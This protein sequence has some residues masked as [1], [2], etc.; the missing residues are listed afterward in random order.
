MLVPALVAL[1]LLGASQ[2]KLMQAQQ[3]LDAH[4]CDGLA[5]MFRQ[6]DASSARDDL[7]TA[8]FLVQAATECRKKDKLL[9]LDLSQKA[10]KLAPTDYGVS[11]SEAE[12]YLALD[13][14]TEAAKVLND[15]IQDHPN[16]AARARMLRGQLADAEN[17]WA[18][19]VQVLKP[20]QDD[21]EYGAK[22]KEILARAQ[23]NLQAN[24]QAQAGMKQT[25][26]QLEENAQAAEAIATARGPMK[27]VARSGTLVWTGKGKVASGGSKTF[28]TKNIK[29]G[30]DYV[31][32]TSALCSGQKKKSGRSRHKRGGL[33]EAGPDTFGLTFKA[34]IGSLDPIPLDVGLKPTHTDVPFRA[35]EDNPQIR[36]E[37][38]TDSKVNV[39]CLISDVEVRVP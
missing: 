39:K 12:S 22:A 3:L 6:V 31:I 24:A 19:A 18:I 36:I 30:V 34:F 35:I 1:S 4:D 17:D 27:G 33:G 7:A 32:H 11:T 8:R 9:A 38:M 15:T 28:L 26:Q 16:E 13:L 10:A 14:R 20:I 37:D 5:S 21:P 29:A 2:A 23:A 25:E